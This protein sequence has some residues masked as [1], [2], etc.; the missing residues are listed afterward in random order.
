MSK[1]GR[2]R[3]GIPYE[4]VVRAC[5]EI[6]QS[7]EAV[8]IRKVYEITG[9]SYSTIAEFVRRWQEAVKVLRDVALP[10]ELISSLKNAYNKMLEIER[11]QHANEINRER[12]N[13][14][15]TLKQVVDL[16]SDCE[17][18]G[19]KIE[20]LTQ[21]YQMKVLA[22]EKRVAAAESRV[23]D[24][25]KREAEVKQQLESCRKELHDVQ[26]KLAISDTKREELEKVLKDSKGK[27]ER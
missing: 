5:R 18:L 8:T 1:L 12:K 4:Q 14:D 26:L 22:F 20:S 9:G 24:T 11:K 27:G 2:G 3:P 15:D 16:E 23:D 6:E 25:L 17:K 10:D 13:L 21:D 7:G 19:K